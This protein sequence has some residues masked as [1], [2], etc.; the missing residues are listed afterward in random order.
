MEQDTQNLAKAVARDA[1]NCDAQNHNHD[2]TDTCVEYAAKQGQAACVPEP[3]E[4]EATKTKASSWTVPPCRLLL[5][6]ILVFT[7]LELTRE[8]VLRALR[9]SKALVSKAY[10]AIR[11]KHNKHEHFAPE[12]RQAFRSSS[13]DVHQVVFYCN[14]DVQFKDR[15]VP[16]DVVPDGSGAAEPATSEPRGRGGL[17]FGLRLSRR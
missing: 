9:R 4:G 6:C 11:N 5:Y 3:N 17:L 13:S 16:A 2:C 12:S 8:L 1:R 14:G 10:I 15:A 7:V